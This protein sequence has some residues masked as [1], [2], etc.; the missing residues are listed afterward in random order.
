[1]TSAR[2]VHDSCGPWGVSLGCVAKKREKQVCKKKG[3]DV[4]CAELLFDSFRCS[5]ARSRGN[6][7]VIDQDVQF[8]CDCGNVGCCFSDGILRAEVEGDD[9][10]LGRG[11]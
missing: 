1:M 3:A 8:V 11:V 10:N 5:G 4:V 6:S 9:F 7:S 2:E